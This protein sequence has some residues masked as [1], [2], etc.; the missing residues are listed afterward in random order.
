ML[1]AHNCPTMPKTR[2]LVQLLHHNGL[3]YRQI[4]VQTSVNYSTCSRI[5]SRFRERGTH[6]NATRSGRPTIISERD[7]RW[8]LR[9]MLK[10]RFQTLN[11]IITMLGL[12]YSARTVYTFLQSEGY[13]RRVARKKPF[14]TEKQ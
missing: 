13:N 1:R 7:K 14:L 9:T 11:S 10:D 8:I 2:K 5:L 12:E 4:Q 6:E 3:S